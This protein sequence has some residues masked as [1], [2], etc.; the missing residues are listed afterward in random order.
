MKKAKWYLAHSC[1][2][3][4]SVRRWELRVQGHYNVD[5]INPFNRNEFENVEHLKT[6]KSKRKILAYM[7]TLDEDTCDKIVKHD[8][9]LL[10][11]SDGVVA[12]FNDFTA[13]TMM[14]VF[15]GAYLY[16]IPV[17]IISPKKYHPWV[18]SLA[19]RLFT[20]RRAFEQWLDEEGYRKD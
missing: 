2:L 20:S 11:K 19:T 18:R 6:L 13:G 4:E 8:L 3:I 12:V 15:A 17:Y 14:E 1:Q 7:K 16:R 9:D 5:L 10:R